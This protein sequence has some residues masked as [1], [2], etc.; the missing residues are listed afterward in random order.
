MATPGF[1]TGPALGPLT[2]Y[3]DNDPAEL[4]ALLP[5]K[6]RK[7]FEIL[8]LRRDDSHKLIPA[9]ETMRALGAEKFGLERA[10]EKMQARRPEG[11]FLPDEDLRVVSAKSRLVRL[12]NEVQ[13]I[14][15]RYETRGQAFAAI[16]RTHAD[17]MDWIRNRPPNTVIEDAAEPKLNGKVPLLDQLENVRRRGRELTSDLNRIRSSC[18][19]SE[20]C[21]RRMVEIVNGLAERR[22]PSM[23]LLVEHDRPEIGWPQLRRVACRRSQSAALRLVGQALRRGAFRA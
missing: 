20:H 11:D 21:K 6:A 13:A 8:C 7:R 22:R 2:L 19:P 1:E 17:A 5:P 16:A 18:Y 10:I 15:E 12:T 9:A 3:V 14:R 4:A 23:A